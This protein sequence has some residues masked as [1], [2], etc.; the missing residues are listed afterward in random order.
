MNNREGISPE[1]AEEEAEFDRLFEIA[2]DNFEAMRDAPAVPEDETEVE[3]GPGY[4][5]L[6]FDGDE[7]GQHA[8]EEAFLNL[9][10]LT[11]TMRMFVRGYSL[12]DEPYSHAIAYL[13]N[14][15]L[16][17]EYR[18][19]GDREKALRLSDMDPMDR[20]AWLE[21]TQ[22]Q[23][24]D[25]LSLIST[26]S[27]EAAAYS[28]RGGKGPAEEFNEEHTVTAVLA[29]FDIS[30]APGR[31][32]PCPA[33]DDSSPSLTVMRHD[34]RVYCHNPSCPLYGNGHGE[35]AYG[36]YRVLAETRE[37]GAGA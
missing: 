12:R 24:A 20:T 26:R 30:A 17:A 35:G 23:K 15:E 25:C 31:N 4:V 33:H 13:S 9:L 19:H 32:I 1:Q 21:L 22:V 6:A 29:M 3:P 28:K 27:Q 2:W 5:V 7:A 37:E 34:R 36:L 11:P 10:A 14:E 8:I 18:L 16:F